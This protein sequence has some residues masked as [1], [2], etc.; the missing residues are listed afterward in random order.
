[1]EREREV[2][3]GQTERAA[4]RLDDSSAEIIHRDAGV[5]R[6]RHCK[7]GSATNLKIRATPIDF[8]SFL[9]V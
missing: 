1:M 7:E 2:A 8:H 9:N 4:R 5:W 6:T 3:A